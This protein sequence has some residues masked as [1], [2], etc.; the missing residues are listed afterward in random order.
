MRMIAADLWGGVWV[1]NTPSCV[2]WY[3]RPGQGT[4]EHVGFAALHVAHPAAIGLVDVREGNRSARSAA[5]WALGNYAWMLV[6]SLGIRLA[7]PRARLPLAVAASAAGVALARRLGASG[8]APWFGP[9]YYAKLLIGHA[10]GSVWP[11]VD[12]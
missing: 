10:A 9:V 8:A 3:E 6:S 7:P 2:R 4:A 11:S 5:N 1:N 12:D